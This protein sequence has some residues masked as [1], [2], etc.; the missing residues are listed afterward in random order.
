MANIKKTFNFRN[1][2][3]V[4]EDNLI[5]NATG[6]VGIGTTI[7][8]EALDV[9][10]TAKVVG[11]VT[12][13]EGFIGIFTAH[14]SSLGTVALSTSI[15]GAGVSIKSGIITSNSATG[16]VT[17]YGDARFLQGM[18][19]SQWE[20][21][22]AG[23]GVSSI[24]N[25]GGTVG[26]ATTN[27]Q[28]T[29]Q[30]GDNVNNGEQG[31]GISSE[32][33][34]KASG[35]VTATSFVGNLTGN[36]N[37]TTLDSSTLNVSGVSTF[38]NAVFL[39]NTTS[40]S[41]SW[42][43]VSN[44]LLVSEDCDIAFGDNSEMAITHYNDES[45]VRDQRVGAAATLAIQADRVILRNKDATENYLEA[46]DNDSVKIYYDSVP[47]LETSGVGVTVYNQLD[48]T[49]MV[50]SG[51]STLGVSTFTGAVSFGASVS[52]GDDDFA[53]FGH[54]GDL[55]I[56]HDSGTDQSTILSSKK[57]SLMSAIGIEIE[58]ESGKQL[59]DFTKGGASRLFFNANGD[60]TDLKFTTSGV[61]VTV[62]NQ[63]D[64]TNIVAS[65][66][67][68]AT[69]ELNSPLVGVGTDDPATDIQVRKSG[70]AQIRVTSDSNAAIVS[71]GRESGAGNGNNAALRYGN[72]NAAFDYSTN[73][74]LD[75]LN[76]STGNINFNLDGTNQISNI[77][78]FYWSKYNNPVMTLTSGGNLGIGITLPEY[79]LHVVG[80]STFAGNVT[81]SSNL[82]VG[83]NFALSAGSFTGN[84]TGKLTGNVDGL[85]NSVVG[86]N[87]VGLLKSEDGIGIG[88]TSGGKRL[89]VNN[90]NNSEFYI[91]EEGRVGICTT[92]VF[93]DVKLAVPESVAVF[94]V[95]G[96]GTTVVRSAADFSVAG[97]RSNEPNANITKRFMIPPL[98]DNAG[99][100]NLTGL[101]AGAMIFNTD[102]NKLNVYNGTAWR[103]VTDGA[104]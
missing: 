67:I 100:G 24:F 94:S 17:Y 51:V 5:V 28:F 27:P 61:G 81:C 56:Y 58:D 86:M 14:T 76:Y 84:V 73:K 57:I 98:L 55:S 63:L 40:D 23:F 6:L 9:R 52:F 66:V 42:N 69:T 35:I 99:R 47:K 101:V 83:G 8:T 90:N 92:R 15:I 32:G 65:G 97:A 78:N 3:Q 88:V 95:V 68:T 39:G 20:D 96:V 31:V 26:I 59:A 64:T 91:D 70:A 34:I 62:Y 43:K 80:V 103:E 54:N 50:V 4:D 25:T 85:I 13:K 104:V 38:N 60:A 46:T 16:L 75:I 2:V 41:I 93:T 45:L 87:T 10:G 77:G 33:N 72:I 30:V 37:A 74:S 49:N 102:T 21:T 19:T 12:S 29:L 89:K 53:K 82:T 22:N 18:P 1:G 44:R 79:R 48:T 11:L 71:V 36:V 7:P